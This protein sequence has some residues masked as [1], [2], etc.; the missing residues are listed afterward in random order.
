MV[1]ACQRRGPV[2][3][4]SVA[5]VFSGVKK[6]TK[7]YTVNTVVGGEFFVRKEMETGFSDEYQVEYRGPVIGICSGVWVS[8]RE[9]E[10][11]GKRVRRD[12]HVDGRVLIV[13][14]G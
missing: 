4:R 13:P 2:R 6:L 8:I 9:D 7:P 14:R 1:D 10:T 11:R 5:V 3:R 12:W